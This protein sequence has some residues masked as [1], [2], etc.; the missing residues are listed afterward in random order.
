M[1]SNTK[2]TYDLE[3][4]LRTSAEYEDMPFLRQLWKFIM[5]ITFPIWIIPYLVVRRFRH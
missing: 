4:G 2:D 5:L 1:D 3:R